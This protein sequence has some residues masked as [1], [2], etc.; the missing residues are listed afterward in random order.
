MKSKC[1]TVNW[2]KVLYKFQFD[3]KRMS[4][5][6]GCVVLVKQI[7]RTWMKTLLHCVFNNLRLPWKP[8]F[9]W[10]FSLHWIYFLPF[11]ISEQLCACLENRVALEFF[12]VL[13]IHFTFRSFEQL[14]CACPEKQRVP[15]IHSTD[16]IFFIIQEIWVIRTCP[17]K[18]EL[19]R[20][21]S[22]YGLYHFTHWIFEQ[23]VL[24]QKNRGFPEFTVPNIYCLLFRS[25]EQPALSLK[26]KAALE[27][28]TVF[29]MRYTFR[30][31]EQIALV[32]KAELP[33]KF[34]LYGIYFCIQNFRA[35][36]ACPEKQSCPDIFH[37][38]EQVFFIIQKFLVSCAC[39]EKQRVPWNFSLYGKYFS[40]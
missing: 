12:T 9:P 11:R 34:S 39:P 40:H 22:L 5:K 3:T 23:L 28:F 31:S 37:C 17:E 19:P 36:C 1:T 7:Y 2:Q 20:N 21:F 30:S 33:W 25:F 32:L 35:V 26:N 6:A 16:Y 27:F 4:N 29:N 10:N 15:W 13:N 38:I 8:S 18:T 14:A 24:S